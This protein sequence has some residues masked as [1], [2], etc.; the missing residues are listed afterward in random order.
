[1][2]DEAKLIRLIIESKIKKEK[3]ISAVLVAEIFQKLQN[4]I[5]Y[6]VDDLEDNPPRRAGDF[7]NSVKERAELVISEMHIGSADA[8][9][10]LS[11][12]QNGLFDNMTLGENAISI[13]DN[14]IQKVSEG[15]TGFGLSTFIKNGLRQ[16]RII[17]EFEGIWP[18]DQSK[19]D[20]LVGFGKRD[21]T[22]LKPSQRHVLRDLIKRPPENVEKSVTGRLMEVR[23]DQ[24]RSFQ[25]DTAEGVVACSYI[26]DLENKVIENIGRLVRIRG[27][28]ALGKNGKYTLSLDNENSLVDLKMLPLDRIKMRGKSFDLKEPMMLNVSYEDDTYWV[29][30]DRFHMRG[31]GAT[32][33]AAIEDLSEEAEALWEDYVE[34]GLE[35]LT[36]DALDLRQ[37]LLS[38]FSGDRVNANI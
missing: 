9:L 37:E 26:S 22:P 25:I 13:A 38:A 2:S 7:P 12:S 32:L 1:M 14:L 10:M 17:H 21:A 31:F 16:E 24:R 33:K 28:M 29:F 6:I 20:I 8:E 27:M 36:E 15:D 4:I 18:D 34:A 11:D 30:S 35:E 19:Y 5:Y 3:H 23:V